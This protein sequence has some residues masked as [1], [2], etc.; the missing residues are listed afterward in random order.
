M[1]QDEKLEI[2]ERFI[3]EMINSGYGRKNIRETVISGLRTGWLS[4]GLITDL[5]SKHCLAETGRSSLRTQL[6][7][8]REMRKRMMKR[9]L[10]GGEDVSR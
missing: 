9:L 10:P 1:P 3:H 8:K 7:L 6:D 5:P 2:T 4:M